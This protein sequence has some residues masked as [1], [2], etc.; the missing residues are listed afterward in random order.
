MFM[1]FLN[2][3]RVKKTESRK[4]VGLIACV[5]FSAAHS[6]FAKSGEVDSDWLKFRIIKLLKTKKI[7]RKGLMENALGFW[8]PEPDA[9]KKELAFKKL[10]M[11]I[12]ERAIKEAYS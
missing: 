6:S 7:G 12:I 1:R 2:H 9:E 8:F 10:M 3:G 4:N 5:M 11:I